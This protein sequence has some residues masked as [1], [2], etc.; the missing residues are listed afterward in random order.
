MRTNHTKTHPLV[1][2]LQVVFS[3]H[4]DSTK[5]VEMSRYMKNHFS[6]Y[7]I[8]KPQRAVIQKP[9][10][11]MCKAQKSSELIPVV[12]QLWKLPERENQYTCLDIL[13]AA[14]RQADDDMF[15]VYIELV[16]D[17][18]WW[19]T[20]DILA[21]NLIGGYCMQ[22]HKDYKPM[23]IEFS[24]HD[25]IWLNRVALLHQLKYKHRTDE[26]LLIDCISN[27]KHKKEFFVQK[28]I[29]WALRQHSRINPAFIKRYCDKH[30]LSNL[31]RREALKIISS[32]KMNKV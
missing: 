24:M 19:D 23:F 13:D 9:F 26:K 17:K 5:S 12:S 28:A 4:A 11:G 8:S 6:F 25:N 2:E 31:A 10:I 16:T 7:G 32:A 15:K 22:K 3:S 27:C 21:S 14:R 1:T 30:A 18:S 20:V 29:G